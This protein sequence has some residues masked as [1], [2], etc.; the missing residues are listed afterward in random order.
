[1]SNVTAFEVADLVAKAW[2]LPIEALGEL[3]PNTK[4]PRSEPFKRPSYA[5][6]GCAVMLIRKHTSAG[7]AVI[8]NAIHMR[9]RQWDARLEHVAGMF[10]WWAE[11]N[12][13]I[14]AR[15][16]QVECWIDEIHEWRAAQMVPER[17]R[18]TEI[19]RNSQRMSAHGNMV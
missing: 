13:D 16:E 15:V 10:E 12:P 17:E 8:S 3:S 4:G 18:I 9:R 19:S 14:A 1:M 6:R 7:A 2:G 5:A 11:S